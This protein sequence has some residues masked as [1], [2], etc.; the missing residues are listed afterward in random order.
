MVLQDQQ[1]RE[2]DR[3]KGE[4]VCRS[5]DRRHQR[6]MEMMVFVMAANSVLPSQEIYLVTMMKTK[7]A[8]NHE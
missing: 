3:R 4:E 1:R 8:I 7:C 6:I 2:E 5:E